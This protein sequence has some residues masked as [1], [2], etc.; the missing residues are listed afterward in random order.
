MKKKLVGTYYAVLDFKKLI[1][2][3]EFEI[4]LLKLYRL[5]EKRLLFLKKFQIQKLLIKKLLF[6]TEF[7][8][9]K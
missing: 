2:L 9:H 5:K 7:L 1:T 3:P 8:L 6:L 4:L